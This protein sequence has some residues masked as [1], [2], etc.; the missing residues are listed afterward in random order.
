[1]Q[2]TEPQSLASQ[3]SM[4]RCRQLSCPTAPIIN[5]DLLAFALAQLRTI[6]LFAVYEV[7]RICNAL[8]SEMHC[9]L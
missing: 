9:I 1:M 8:S 3:A 5:Q 6:T 2:T 7:P 4:A